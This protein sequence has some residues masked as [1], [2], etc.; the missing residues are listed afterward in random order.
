MPVV[1]NPQFYFKEGFCWTNVSTPTHE[2][3][4]FIKCRL[5]GKS[6]NDVASMSMYNLC[7][8]TSNYYFITL[9]NSRYFYNYL[10]VFINN[11]VNLQI[12]D[13][14]QFPII[15]PTKKQ[16]DDFNN[17]FLQ[18]YQIKNKHYTNSISNKEIDK[19]FYKIQSFLE[20]KVSELYCTI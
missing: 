12:N 17:I 14:R 5:K 19:E 9:L 20:R 7:E 10:K 4:M 13:F 8:K 3:S 16:L 11:S 18:A 2:E 1:R 6:I 15:I